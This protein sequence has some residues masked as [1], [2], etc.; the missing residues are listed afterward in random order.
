[1]TELVG[2]LIETDPVE[3]M[4]RKLSF[5]YDVANRV[6]ERHGKMGMIDAA[7]VGW[8]MPT[9]KKMFS[10]DNPDLVANAAVSILVDARDGS[11]P[12][13]WFFSLLMDQ[14]PLLEES[15]ANYHANGEKILISRQLAFRSLLT[16][17]DY[18]NAESR[19]EVAGILERNIGEC[20]RL[21]IVDSG[22]KNHFM[23]FRMMQVEVGGEMAEKHKVEVMEMASKKEGMEGVINGLLGSAEYLSKLE[24]YKRTTAMVNL[25]VF[26]GEY[27]SGG[28]EAARRKMVEDICKSW[29]TIRFDKP[30]EV[31]NV[32]YQTALE[33]AVY[34]NIAVMTSLRNFGGDDVVFGINKEYGITHFGRYHPD[35]L[36]KQWL[37]KD[38]NELPF[39]VHVGCYA[40]WNG[41]F[42]LDMTLLADFEQSARAVGRKVVF[43]EARNKFTCVRRF[44]EL[45]RR[46]KKEIDFLVLAGHSSQTTLSLGVGYKEGDDIDL[47]DLR[48][49]AADKIKRIYRKNIPI[50]FNSCSVGAKKGLAH[51]FSNKFDGQCIGPDVPTSVQSLK[52]GLDLDGRSYFR[53]VVY[54]DA[55][56]ANYRSGRKVD[57]VRS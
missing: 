51:G 50:L 39:G 36:K 4:P 21:S 8:N 1:M 53:D 44:K 56:I 54:S 11:E 15:L 7:R 3:S 9:Y 33:F 30:K 26:K 45:H 55:K 10:G 49:K 32:E 34:Q 42:Y 12:K 43:V 2:N 20:E 18:G 19:V 16:L 38:N 29:L 25:L 40:D 48:S 31:G 14:L 5:L 47:A 37:E 24:V 28:D 41:A 27:P 57:N 22:N 52:L 46:Y 35:I 13:Q 23:G 6:H 17:Y